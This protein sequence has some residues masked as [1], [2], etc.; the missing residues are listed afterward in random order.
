MAVTGKCG[1]CRMTSDSESSTSSLAPPVVTL[2]TS[3]F[4]ERQNPDQRKTGSSLLDR[5]L[6]ERRNLDLTGLVEFSLTAEKS[7]SGGFADVYEG[8]LYSPEIG[9]PIRVAIKRL[10]LKVSNEKL[11]KV[12]SRSDM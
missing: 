12:S 4:L 7:D 8:S 6:G 11:A 9:K 2:K 3:T 10:R 1:K 5:V